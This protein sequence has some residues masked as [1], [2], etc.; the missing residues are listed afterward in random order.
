MS[1]CKLPPSSN[2]ISRSGTALFS[3]GYANGVIGS[4]NTILTRI[5]GKAAM[6]KNNYST[7]LSSLAFAGTIV[8]MVSFG[9]L[10]DKVGRKFGMMFASGIVAV[11][12]GLSAASHGANGSLGGMLAMLSACRFLLGIGI[13]AEYSC[14]AVAAAELSEEAAIKKAAQHRW[15]TLSTN[16]VLNFGIVVSSFV[17][18]VAYWIFGDNHLRAVWR[19]SLGL[20][21]VPAIAVFVWRMMQMEETPSYRKDSMKRVKIPYKLVIKRYWRSLL[22]LCIVWCIYDFIL[23]PFEI[24]SSTVINTITGG[25]QSLE[26]IF[27]WNVVINLLYMPGTIGGAFLMDAIG[28]KYCQAL[29]LT[30]QAVVGF[31]L[32]ALYKPLTEH[33]AAFAILYGLFLSFSE[34][35]PGNC[36]FLL[37]AKTAP[38]AV[39]GQFYG[40]AAAAGKVGALA[41]IWAFP[42]ITNGFG[43]SI[44]AE[45]GPFWIASGL[46]VFST[47]VTI[48]MVKPLSHDCMMEEDLLFRE[49]LEAHG[50]DTC[51]MGLQDEV[52]IGSDASID[53][54]DPS[55][56]QEK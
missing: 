44:L 40:I 4:V 14:G 47:L 45:T 21:V 51:L 7:T 8:G 2:T 42:A 10:A 48:F 55:V 24:F 20:G 33:V 49:Y 27:G 16:S 12:S 41:G 37:S 31:L 9:Y 39:R 13:G 25:S 32:S 1:H 46:V 17:P 28:P 35:G 23:Y 53:K 11:F 38:T 26:V 52:T 19:L 18:L 56:P 15:F 6:T 5:Y 54:F 36:V 29:G 50:F 34:V 3:D 43:N 22:P 30:L